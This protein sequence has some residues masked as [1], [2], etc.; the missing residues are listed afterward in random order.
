[1]MAMGDHFHRPLLRRF[2]AANGVYPTGT[3]VGLTDGR[4][5]R[6]IR[7]TDDPARPVVRP[8]GE[9]PPETAAAEVDLSREVELAVVGAPEDPVDRLYEPEGAGVGC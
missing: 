7:Q 1:M 3:L 2:I 9:L 5:G 8:E 6:V 4:R